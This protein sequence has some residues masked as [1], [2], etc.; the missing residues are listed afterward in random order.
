MHEYLKMMDEYHEP[1]AK[2]YQTSIILNQNVDC[3]LRRHANLLFVV[4][5]VLLY[6]THKSH[7]LQT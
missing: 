3:I 4:D 2:M 1:L 6:S 5:L 7:Y